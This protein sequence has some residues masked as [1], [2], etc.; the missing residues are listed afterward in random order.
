M[1]SSKETGQ[2]D[3]L[4]FIQGWVDNLVTTLNRHSNDRVFVADMIAAANQY[5]AENLS[6]QEK[7]DA[8]TYL[9][10]ILVRKK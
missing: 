5:F 7:T 2:I 10:G 1:K 8:F 3:D 9:V 6:S 4:M